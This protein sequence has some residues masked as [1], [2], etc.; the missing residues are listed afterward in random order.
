VHVKGRAEATALI[1]IAAAIL[2]QRGYIWNYVVASTGAVWQDWEGTSVES[3][4]A[5]RI[6]CNPIICNTNIPDLA[7][8]R[9]LRDAL[10]D[11]LAQTDFL[12]KH[13]NYADSRFEALG[14]AD[15]LVAAVRFVIREQ[16]REKPVSYDMF[17]HALLGMAIDGYK[18]AYEAVGSEILNFYT[19]ETSKKFIKRVDEFNPRGKKDN[20]E[21]AQ[22]AATDLARFT[23][24]TTPSLL[25]AIPFEAEVRRITELALAD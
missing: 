11:P 15:S 10:I 1:L 9:S 5:H 17:R 7:R 20:I 2:K 23:G 24:T 3:E 22:E 6:P 16:D 14:A 4:R 12:P 8:S 18:R 21:A 19:R 13:A 25:H